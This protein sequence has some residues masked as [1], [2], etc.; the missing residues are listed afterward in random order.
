MW[1]HHTLNVLLHDL[2]KYL[3][4]LW[5]TVINSLFFVLS[6]I[7]TSTYWLTLYILY[8]Y[9]FEICI[10]FQYD[11][12][13]AWEYLLLFFWQSFNLHVIPI[14]HTVLNYVLVVSVC[15]FC[16]L[17]IFSATLYCI[18]VGIMSLIHGVWTKHLFISRYCC[19]NCHGNNCKYLLWCSTTIYLMV[20]VYSS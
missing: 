12:R 16:I 9:L 18:I 10:A 6:Y 19:Y 13:C 2:V 15:L 14:I 11:C 8:C 4:D 3:V 20:H 7:F 5:L 17:K 1:W